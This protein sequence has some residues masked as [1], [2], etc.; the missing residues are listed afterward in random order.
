MSSVG[1]TADGHYHSFTA[2]LCP[3]EG[4][5]FTTCGTAC[6]PTCSDPGPVVCTAQCVIGCQCPA[7]TV[8]DEVEQK[9][10]TLDQCGT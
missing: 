9:C 6:P 4:Q 10:V 7:G 5:Q 8:L 2:E 1:D 3:I